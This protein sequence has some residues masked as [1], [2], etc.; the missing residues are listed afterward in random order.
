[1]RRP[2]LWLWLCALA[3]RLQPAL[4][5]TVA[6]NVPPEDQDGSGDDSDNFSGSG[7]GASLSS[8]ALLLALQD[9]TFDVSAENSAGATVEPGQRN[10]PPGDPG[11]TGASQGL[12]DRK[13]VLG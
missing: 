4:P 9:F 2:A 12:L 7:A 11:A 5:Q 13:E 6:V 3:L 10:G 8:H 1:M